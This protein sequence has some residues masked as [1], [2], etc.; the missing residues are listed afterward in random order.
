MSLIQLVV[1]DIKQAIQ[2]VFLITKTLPILSKSYAILAT[3]F[4]HQGF[5]IF[6]QN[7]A[8]I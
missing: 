6:T 4:F 1:S 2:F 5:K 3:V 7:L 8:L